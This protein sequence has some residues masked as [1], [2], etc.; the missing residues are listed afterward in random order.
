V[1]RRNELLADCL[2]S[3]EQYQRQ[4]V[5]YVI[6][7]KDRNL[8]ISELHCHSNDTIC[9]IVST[10]IKSIDFGSSTLFGILYRFLGLSTK[11]SPVA[12]RFQRNSRISDFQICKEIKTAR[13]SHD[14]FFGD[15]QGAFGHILSKLGDQVKVISYEMWNY[16]VTSCRNGDFPNSTSIKD[17]EIRGWFFG[18]LLVKSSCQWHRKKS[19][20]FATKKGNI[21][22]NDTWN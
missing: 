7:K 20:F 1:Q 17:R 18:R 9:S 21:A 19:P 5:V 14:T 16:E 2:W 6:L 12:V 15:I 11:N 22:L 4:S 8:I 3:N 13:F 10:I